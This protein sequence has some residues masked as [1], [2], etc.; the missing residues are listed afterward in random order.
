MGR[1]EDVGSVRPDPPRPPRRNARFWSGLALLAVMTGF[2]LF[3]AVTA[4]DRD[5]AVAVRGTTAQ[6]TI[7]DYAPPTRVV[8][9]GEHSSEARVVFLTAGGRRVDT[10]VPVS[11]PVGVGPALVRYEVRNPKT[12]R[13]VADPGPNRRGPQ[14]LLGLFV[15]LAAPVLVI[16][17]LVL[18]ARR[19]LRGGG[20]GI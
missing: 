8:W 18:V 11:R 2:L 5:R 6:G 19:V 7:V 3:D 16:T 1:V 9:F 13:L 17:A 15:L 4:Q 12:A 14:A 20:S 10:W